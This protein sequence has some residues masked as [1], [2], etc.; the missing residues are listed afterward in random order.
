MRMEQLYQFIVP[1]TFM[2]IWALTALLNREAQPL[3]PRTTGRPPG[4][5]PGPGPRTASSG[6][7]TAT[8]PGAGAGAG[9]T[10]PPV[11]VIRV[12]AGRS[13]ARSPEILILESEI[14]RPSMPDPR[15]QGPG[16]ATGSR[17]PQRNRTAPAAQGRGSTASGTS[18]RALTPAP[19]STTPALAATQPLAPMSFEPMPSSQSVTPVSARPVSTPETRVGL[20]DLQ[21]LVESPER[22]RET[23]L[24]NEILAP[25]IALRRGPRRGL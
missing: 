23:F 5:G 6:P 2:A 11:E 4:P 20:V 14:R 9:R 21:R 12:P 10:R 22:L 18:A 8:A 16:P 15:A 25:P 3:P 13:P 1:L 24:M 17:R 7:A 19:T